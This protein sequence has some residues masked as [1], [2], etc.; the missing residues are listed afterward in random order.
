MAKSKINICLGLVIFCVFF[1][2]CDAP[3]KNPLDPQNTT[4]IRASLYGR[5]FS[6]AAPT[7]GLSDVVVVWKNN[8]LTTTDQN[9]LYTFGSIH[10][11]SGWLY[12][13]KAGFLPDS[14]YLEWKGRESVEQ[15][16]TLRREP[17][18]SGRV[19]TLRVPP[20]PIPD[21]KVTWQPGQQYTYTNSDGYYFFDRPQQSDG[22]LTFEKEG[23]RTFDIPIEWPAGQDV[24]KNAFLNAN[25]RLDDFDLFS[26][27]KNYYEP[28][29]P[30][31]E[32]VARASLGDTEGDIDSVY[33]EC[34]SLNIKAYLEYN[35]LE[36]VFER[37]FSNLDLELASLRQVVGYDFDL[38]VIDRFGYKFVLGQE[39]I[40]R[41][42]TDEIE[43]DSP[44]NSELVDHQV[45]LKWLHFD[46]GFN[47]T[48]HAKIHTDD[49]FTP[50]LV[51]EKEGIAADTNSVIAHISKATDYVW[52]IW[53]VDEFDNRSRS[54]QGSFRV[55]D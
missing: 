48:F 40:A 12:F 39:R 13:S 26:V 7:I 24:T 23:Y 51:W 49:D 6:A 34:P 54:K 11:V 41:I 19:Q 32:L 35:V 18:L 28:R 53:C 27:V 21:V 20:S 10:P 8:R 2:R 14:V 31:D 17:S 3:R 52:E 5:V 15:N 44:N 43:I 37:T 46:P 16:M 47:F 38:C 9:G 45:T 55:K 25:P 50:E 36:R 42:I 29:P 1:L 33:I 30:T 4:V 22:L